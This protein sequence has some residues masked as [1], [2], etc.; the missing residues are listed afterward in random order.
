MRHATIDPPVEPAV[1]DALSIHVTASEGYPAFERLCLAARQEIV[2]GFR[3]F[4]MSTGLRSDEGQAIGRDWFDLLLHVA[5]RGVALRFVLSDFDAV[6]GTELHGMT[7]RTMRQAAA[8]VELA[9]P[10]ADIRFEAS[11]HPAQVGAL[12]RVALWP[13]V[14]R[15]LRDRARRL[16][17]LDRPRRL[18]FMSNHPHL[19]R[20]MMMGDDR[21][22][23]R[24]WPLPPLAPVTHH[25]KAAAIDG[26]VAYVG[27]LDLNER[28]W[29]TRAHDR[30][31]PETWHDVHA[32]LRDP[33]T[34]RAL[35]AH[36][37]ELAGVIALDA[38]P[39]DLGKTLLRTVST[40]RRRGPLAL[41]PKVK[42]HT[43]QDAI[44]EGIAR[45]QRLI[46]L[47]TQFL[48]DRRVSK[49]LARRA[50]QVPGLELVVMLPARP[51]DVA[52]EGT[53]RIDARFGEFLQ[54]LAIRRLRRAF[55]GRVFVGTLARRVTAQGA[56]RSVVHGAPLIYLHSKVS[57]FDDRLGVI[58][59]ANL[60]GRSLR[61][62][63][64]VAIAIA[65]PM[66]VARLRET[67][68][69]GVLGP[70]IDPAPY[71]SL[72]G[73]VRAWQHLG[74]RNA[75]TRPEAREGFVVPYLARP[76]RRFGRPLRAVPE[77]MV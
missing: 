73:A 61:W 33:E 37:D 56:G 68:M 8:L 60:N 63:T 9:G 15:M 11:L 42:V 34:A 14:D 64:E 16:L 50:R 21:V 71:A 45:S 40:K 20:M 41:S 44:L 76:G 67:C 30:A 27:G 29:D 39:S 66:Q 72:D 65:D 54:Y 4:D 77:E 59:S 10:G 69:G 46:Y 6:V 3:I 70:G 32:T 5:R 52:F 12:A 26:K 2:A 58:G 62:D 49:A 75:R 7:W 17:H 53:R 24:R 57:T 22:E 47:E 74:L 23:P 19:S 38:E 51:E 25:Q 55:R 18:R 1:Q 13:R 35:R 36:L 31:S 28:R 43:I 48:R